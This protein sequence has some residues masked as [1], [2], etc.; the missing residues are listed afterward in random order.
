MPEIEPSADEIFAALGDAIRLSLLSRLAQFKDGQSL[1]ISTLTASGPLTRQAITKH[2]DVLEKAGLVQSRR[3]GRETHYSLCAE[4][5]VT[6]QKYMSQIC[7][8]WDEALKARSK[9]A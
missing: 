7:R 4:T 8:Q 6:A 5:I 2:L 1:S 3:A 9:T